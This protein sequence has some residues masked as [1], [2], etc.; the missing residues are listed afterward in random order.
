MAFEN[1][2]EMTEST[3]YQDI[4]NDLGVDTVD[5][6]QGV[7]TVNK[8]NSEMPKPA[9]STYKFRS[10]QSEQT[11]NE[12]QEK[13]QLDISVGVEHVLDDSETEDYVSTRE[14]YEKTLGVTEYDELRTKL[15]LKDDES[16]TD[17]YNRTHYVPEGFEMQAKL[18]LAEEKRKKL[19]AEVEAGNMSEEDFLYEAYGKD[20]LKE[21]GIDFSD[22]HYWYKKY[23]NKDYSDP[24]DNATYMLQLIDNARTLFEAETWYEV[25]QT[26]NIQELSQYVT[27]EVLPASTVAE[28]FPEMF[29]ELN[30][31]YESNEQIVK[32]YRGGMLQGFN[33]TI[34]ADGDGKIDYYYSTDGKL[35]NVNETG[36][37]ANTARA[38][39]ND[40]GS[41]NRIVMADTYLGEVSG[42]FLQGAGKLFTGVVDLFALA[43]GAIVD[44]FDGDGFG[45]TVAEVNASMQQ[46]WNG[47]PILGERDYV[48]DTGWKTSDGKTNWGNIGR[49][50][51][52]L[53]GYIVPA[54]VLAVCTGGGSLAKDAGQI[55][56]KEGAKATVKATAKAGAKAATKS[57]LSKAAS[58]T[59]KGVGTALKYTGK[60]AVALTKFNYGFGTGWTARI[61]SA[62]INAA[63]D[64]LQ[65]TATLQVNKERLGL[66]DGE[67]VGK[68]LML[69]GIDF[70]AGITLR[71]VGDETALKAMAKLNTSKVAQGSVDFL[72]KKTPNLWAKI[73]LNTYSTSWGRATV[74]GVNVAMDSAENI[75]TAVAQTSIMQNT[76]IGEA[77]KSVFNNPQFVMNL[78]YQGY[79]TVGDMYRVT[80]QK[81]AAAATD[82]LKM[83]TDFRAYVKKAITD[84]EA[85][86][87]IEGVK[88]LKNL[89]TEYDNLVLKYV[90]TD[91]DLKIKVKGEE[92]GVAKAFS[93]MA[94]EYN[95]R[96]E[97]AA[98]DSRKQTSLAHKSDVAKAEASVKYTKAE[99]ILLSLEE[100][101]TKLGFDDNHELFVKW[102]LDAN[103]AISAYQLAYNEAMFKQIHQDHLAYVKLSNSVFMGG[104]LGRFLYGKE[105][106]DVQAKL[107]TA[108]YSYYYNRKE[109]DHYDILGQYYEDLEDQSKLYNR[110]INKFESS[111]DDILK[112]LQTDTITGDIIQFL[113]KEGQPKVNA[114]G[115]PLYEVPEN[116]TKLSEEGKEVFK[117]WYNGL[118]NKQ[119]LVAEKALFVTIP[120]KGQQAEGTDTFKNAQDYMTI[121]GEIWT[122]VAGEYSPFVKLDDQHYLIKF[123]TIGKAFEDFSKTGMLVRALTN[124][125]LSASSND[126]ATAVAMRDLISIFAE[127]TKDA[128]TALEDNYNFIPGIINALKKGQAFNNKDLAYLVK[129]I[130]SYY[131]S[132]NKEHNTNIQL[133]KSMTEGDAYDTAQKLKEFM[134]DYSDLQDTLMA[135]DIRGE[136]SSEQNKAIVKFLNKYEPINA[137]GSK[138]FKDILA[139]AKAEGIFTDHQLSAMRQARNFIQGKTSTPLEN[140]KRSQ[141]SSTV[142]E[143]NKITHND[144]VEF[145]NTKFADDL[146]QIQRSAKGM[147]AQTVSLRDIGS[148]EDF[149]RY[150]SSR[151]GDINI[152]EL[153]DKD[154]LSYKDDYVVRTMKGIEDNFKLS[155]ADRTSIKNDLEHLFNKQTKN[156]DNDYRNRQEH[157]QNTLKRLEYN[158]TDSMAKEVDIVRE[159]DSITEDLNNSTDM[160]IINLN[161]LTGAEG[162]KVAKAIET[163]TA[164]SAALSKAS[165]VDDIQKILFADNE[166]LTNF[167]KEL[168]TVRRL[169]DIYGSNYIRLSI[170]SQTL[171]DILTDLGYNVNEKLKY[172]NGEVLIPGVYFNNDTKGIK[173]TTNAEEAAAVRSHLQHRQNNIEAERL[174]ASTKFR[175]PMESITNASGSIVLLD[176][177]EKLQP[178]DIIFNTLN[179]V[180]EFN[181]IVA[182]VLKHNIIEVKRGKNAGALFKHLLTSTQGIAAKGS[183]DVEMEKALGVYKIVN[184]FSKLYD[185]KEKKDIQGMAISL[186][187][188][189]ALEKTFKSSKVKPFIFTQNDSD[190]LTTIVTLNPE[191]TPKDF[192][193]LVFKKLTAKNSKITSLAQVLPIYGNNEQVSMTDILHNNITQGERTSIASGY[194][195]LTWLEESESLSLDVYDF[196]KKHG[197]SLDF[198][199]KKISNKDYE[200]ALKYLEGKS[201]NDVIND[202]SL[203]DNMFVKMQRNAY[204]ANQEI[205]ESFINSLRSQLPEDVDLDGVLRILGDSNARRSIGVAIRKALIDNKDNLKLDNGFV[206]VDDTLVSAIRENFK[207]SVLPGR[208]EQAQGYTTETDQVTGIQFGSINKQYEDIEVTDK[209]IQDLL[210]VVPLEYTSIVDDSLSVTFE[211]KLMS[212]LESSSYGTDGLNISTKDLYQL[213]PEE[214]DDLQLMFSGNSALASA[215]KTLKKSKLYIGLHEKRDP[216]RTKEFKGKKT[217]TVQ[218]IRGDIATTSEIAK[219]KFEPALEDE[220]N[221]LIKN[222]KH[223]IA[224]E[225]FIKISNIDDPKFRVNSMMRILAEKLNCSVT[226]YMDNPASL[227]I[228]NLTLGE[229]L[230]YMFKNLQS[231]AG[232]LQEAYGI[233]N[234]DTAI[235]IAVNYMLYSTG[236]QQQGAHPEF[237]IIDKKTGNVVDIAMSGS[238][239][240][241]DDGLITRLYKDYFEVNNGELHFKKS[242]KHRISSGEDIEVTPDN[243]CAL[244]LQRNA[245]TTSFK[246]A[247]Y[248]IEIYD[249]QGHEQ[250]FKNMIMDKI[251]I[252]AQANGFDTSSVDD[253]PRIAKAFMEFVNSR[254]NQATSGFNRRI[255]N[256]GANL[257][258]G[259]DKALLG[260]LEGMSVSNDRL[261]DR[262]LALKYHSDA[263]LEGVNIRERDINDIIN[264]GTTNEELL[265]TQGAQAFIA[266]QNRA[267]S[268]VDDLDAEVTDLFKL[269]EEQERDAKFNTSLKHLAKKYKDNKT[270]AAVAKLEA[271]IK[272]LRDTIR[273]AQEDI[274][275]TKAVKKFMLSSHEKLADLIKENK[276]FEQDGKTLTPL[277]TVLTDTIKA[278]KNVSDEE[279]AINVIKQMVRSS[280]TAEANAFKVLDCNISTIL[281]RPKFESSV[282]INSTPVALSE[283][284]NRPMLVFDTEVF[285][286]GTKQHVYEVSATY[287]VPGKQPITQTRYIKD[288]MVTSIQTLEATYPDFYKEYYKANKGTRVS[289]DNYLKSNYTNQAFDD[290]LKI[291]NADD[292]VL[293]GFNSRN[294][295]IPQLESNGVLTQD[296]YPKLFANQLDLFDIVK[297]LP[298][299]ENINLHGGMAT[300]RHIYDQLNINN[301]LDVSNAHFSEADTAM[302]KQVL[303]QIIASQVTDFKSDLLSDMSSIYKSITGNDIDYA[304]LQ[305]ALDASTLKYQDVKQRY[306]KDL[307]NLQAHL[308][309]VLS[310]KNHFTNM[311]KVIQVANERDINRKVNAQIKNLNKQLAVGI[312]PRY[313]DFATNYASPKTKQLLLDVIAYKLRGITDTNDAKATVDEVKKTMNDIGKLLTDTTSENDI[314]DSLNIN[315]YS[316]VYKLGID[317]DDFKAWQEENSAY[318]HERLNK[319]FHLSYGD[320]LAM[321]TDRTHVKNAVAY[322]TKLLSDYVDGFGFLPDQMKTLIKNEL[323]NYYDFTG[324]YKD[325]SDQVYLDCFSNLDNDIM[326]YLLTDPLLNHSFEQLYRLAQT[327]SDKPITL[328]GGGSEYL[329]NDTVYMTLDNYCKL[330]GIEEVENIPDPVNEYIP[331][332]RHPL[333]KFDSIHFFKIKL[334]DDNQNIDVAINMDTMLS[335]LNGDFD[336]DHITM[337]R[338]SEALSTFAE[339]INTKSGKNTSYDILDNIVES[340]LKGNVKRSLDPDSV[341]KSKDLF[342]VNTDKTIRDHIIK[343]LDQLNKGSTDVELYNKLKTNFINKFKSTYPEDILDKVYIYEANDVSDMLYNNQVIYYSDLLSLNDYQPNTLAKRAYTIAQMSKYKVLSFTDTQSGMFQKGFLNEDYTQYGDVDLVDNMIRLSNSTRY[344]ID[345]VDDISSV[346]PADIKNDSRF[347]TILSLDTTNSNKL[348]LILKI[349]QMESVGNS[350]YKTTVLDATKALKEST[351]NDPFVKAFNRFTSDNTGDAFF[352]TIDQI[353]SIKKKIRGNSFTTSKDKDFINTL[354][355]LAPKFDETIEDS[356]YNPGK[357]MNVIYDL[358]EISKNPEDTVTFVGW[359]KDGGANGYRAV[360]PANTDV[361][362]NQVLSRVRKYKKLGIMSPA[363]VKLLGIKYN[364]NCQYRYVDTQNGIVTY[365]E[366]FNVDT[367]KTV[368][369]GNQASKATPTASIKDLS[370]IKD[371][372][373]QDLIKNNNVSLI[374]NFQDT[375]NPKKSSSEFKVFS[376]SSNY[377]MYK[378]DGTVTDTIDDARYIIAKERRNLLELPQSWNRDLK[379]TKFEELAYGNNMLGTG[380]IGLTYGIFVDPESNQLIIDNTK[381]NHVKEQINS[382]RNYDRFSVDATQLY[383]HL[384]IAAIVNNLSPEELGD[385]TKQQFYID[386]I[387]GDTQE[388]IKSHINK[389]YPLKGNSAKLLDLNLYNRIYGMQQAIVDENNIRLTSGS[390]SGIDKE[391]IF[392]SAN[393]ELHGNIKDMYN[394][395]SG[396]NMSTL[397][398]INYL[399]EGN[400][401]VT[402]TVARKAEQYGFLT[403]KQIPESDVD[404]YRT[405]SNT[406]SKLTQ[407]FQKPIEYKYSDKK[408]FNPD[409]DGDYDSYYTKF[410]FSHGDKLVDIN[411]QRL[412][413]I[414]GNNQFRDIREQ[415]R[416]EWYTRGQRVANLANSLLNIKGTYKDKDQILQALNPNTKALVSMSLPM[417]EIQSNGKIRYNQRRISLG[418]DGYKEVPISEVRQ[419]L[420][421]QRRSPYY[422][423]TLNKLEEQTKA[424]SDYFLTKHSD[425]RK[426]LNP[427]E[428]MLDRETVGTMKQSFSL[429]INQKYKEQIDKYASKLRSADPTYSAAE[430]LQPTLYSGEIVQGHNVGRNLF[431]E[432]PIGLQQGLAHQNPESLKQDRN[433]RQVAVDEQYIKQNYLSKL[434]IIHDIASR[435][436]CGDTLHLFGYVVG[437]QSKLDTLTSK[438][439]LSELDIKAR[440]EDIGITD[441]KKFI[442]DFE[443][444]HYGLATKFYDLIQDLG[445]RSN[446]I[447][448]ASNEPGQNIFFMLLP[449]EYKAR[450]DKKKYVV[451]MLS[452]TTTTDMTSIPAYEAYDVFGALNNTIT[453]VSKRAAIYQN[454][455]RLKQDG[456][457]DSL[458]IQTILADSFKDPALIDKV[459]NT[460]AYDPGQFDLI[461]NRLLD[462]FNNT[463]LSAKIEEARDLIFNKT[464]KDSKTYKIGEAYLKVFEGISELTSNFRTS[465]DETLELANQYNSDQLDSMIYAYR[466]LQDIYAQVCSFNPEI[467]KTLF[468]KINNYAEQNNLAL[469]DKFGRKYDPNMDYK[470]SNTSLEYLP[471]AL[472][473]NLTQYDN[474]IMSETLVGNVFFM[475]KSLANVFADQVFVKVPPNTIQKALQKSSGWCVKM[476]MSSPFKLLDRFFKFTLFDAATLNT[477]NARTMFEQSK[478]YKDLRGYFSSKGGYASPEL[479]E[480]LR[481]QGISFDGTNF[482]GLISGDINAQTPTLFKTYTDKV[483]NAFTFQ[484]LSQRYA[485]WLATKKAIENEDY[486]TLGSAYYLRDKM[487][488]SG[489]TSGEQAA[490]AMGQN[491][492]SMNDFPSLSKKFNKNGFVFTTFPLA[493]VRWGV[494]E[495]RSA[496]SAIHSLFTEGL[497]GSGAKWL[498]RNSVGIIG[499]ILLEQ[500]LIALIADMY[501]VDE[502]DEDRKEWEKVGALPNVTQTLIQGQ[503]IMDSFSSMSVP[504][505]VIN[506][507]IDTSKQDEEGNK[508]GMDGLT[509]FIMSNVVSHV[510]PIV[511]GVG[512]VI[513]KKDVIGD[514][515]IDTSNQYNAFENVFRKTSAYF[516][517]SAGANAAT[518][519]LFKN[520]STESGLEK[521]KNAAIK[522]VNAELGNTKAQKEN[523]KNYYKAMG[524]IN[525]Y[526]YSGETDNVYSNS[527]NFNYSNYSVVKSKIYS[528]MNSE[529]SASEVYSA[530]NDFLASGYTLSEVRSALRNCSISGKLSKINKYEDFIASLTGSELQNLKTALAYEQYMFPW[531]EDNISSISSQIQKNNRRYDYNFDS[532]YRTNYFYDYYEPTNYTIPT[533]SYNYSKNYKDSFDTYKSLQDQLAYNQRQAEY[534]RNQKQW[535]DK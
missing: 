398:L 290:L 456:V 349:K 176:A 434:Q 217:S 219:G 23:K 443:K 174:K 372:T 134:T 526:L 390:G 233:G 401:L 357:E 187:N 374:S 248:D 329:K 213:S 387:S 333:D 299:T 162:N 415:D 514:Q 287:Y 264:L 277:A 495:L 136:I 48:A 313:I 458:K 137:N 243:L 512:E 334:I 85:R 45:S 503:P 499:T 212:M 81:V 527:E 487:I 202:S 272:D 475:D 61:S 47:I 485:Y 2:S 292:A 528:L 242:F 121:A 105:A 369:E 342:K 115:T 464:S 484:T 366:S 4:N 416:D 439:T 135:T 195:T 66:S 74:A 350:T 156:Q 53:I 427:D 533:S 531:L 379:D 426:L 453:A 72:T 303:D 273:S 177:D 291:A 444:Q 91:N 179:N 51:A 124:L 258:K 317:K 241:Q 461:C 409:V 423:D 389:G 354:K 198:A 412:S 256:S 100:M 288:D 175:D 39:Y 235:N 388:F 214:L 267:L 146:K 278:I 58:A 1:D 509:R 358:E 163:Q 250:Q 265:S 200:D 167:K 407:I 223:S 283:L 130:D 525:N 508:T 359:D 319:L 478:A 285:Y 152:E 293:L 395:H 106:R 281:N 400:A 344:L 312:N 490:F 411:G 442:S 13:A 515:I 332:I 239:S 529:A 46:F 435:E 523:R 282:M 228:S 229:N 104:A 289:F 168:R 367:A 86:Q 491:L 226:P 129:D 133:P 142:S 314:I 430:E 63:K 340:V 460:T 141:T 206:D 92:V 414:Y 524:I 64:I 305:G 52:N 513:T 493:A 140:L 386:K 7:A 44:I 30:K 224:T 419:E 221:R 393:S 67:I 209:L 157:L 364:K 298:S 181:A 89:L 65:T 320:T 94:E 345:S 462:K 373:L 352:K 38:V 535:E 17:Y 274:V 279:L 193:D 116:F 32:Y 119:K 21:Q 432:Q 280:N 182:E 183:T 261:K 29:E 436:G 496:T 304:K 391:K 394:M 402:D 381:Y 262:E 330:K 522:A 166:S 55:A 421:N 489:M 268:I 73:A 322:S 71:S 240:D 43:G 54:V 9:A 125:K 353:V 123:E 26:K 158:V 147:E 269:I 275:K 301:K 405:F 216:I 454:A 417:A 78:A 295:D 510:N 259:S 101:A 339:T 93:D 276:Y 497:S 218:S 201:I 90:D 188:A 230:Y 474:Y 413:Q 97:G 154:Y 227:M 111:G 365:I 37:G 49:Q 470:L 205:K 35:Y 335:K 446:K 306:S 145:F 343:D 406:N 244:R 511:K 266:D 534:K 428:V 375:F 360:K 420:Y 325:L 362:S 245:L 488:N 263:D 28:L 237:I 8:V 361:Q 99:A 472:Q 316:L 20:L 252:V 249:F 498:G 377:T 186:A 520:D 300:L 286:N 341:T 397:E 309:K 95:T 207:Y 12:A 336:G 160:V 516:I 418:P 492:G 502:D 191:I 449:S 110:L 131:A 328:R 382:L 102:G 385:R 363:D 62:A 468:S 457:I 31:Y 403:N 222:S 76:S 77:F 473:R 14:L 59:A 530:I 173:L 231:F 36:K 445:D 480:F 331:V 60:A 408:V 506:L 438:D 257:Y 482:D 476:L 192:S 151:Y 324:E 18:L 234:K 327:V 150:L 471:K 96:A 149:N 311:A 441:A 69:G 378:V 68:S 321:D 246:D 184:A 19:Y 75:I 236:M 404:P 494:G 477:A 308:T 450:G 465:L 196:V 112:S 6:V 204:R 25:S 440:L 368:T 15:H 501:G 260:S 103:K 507:F 294:F 70:V 87:D 159:L 483:G 466:Q 251:R 356:I 451:N 132:Y 203:D 302:T 323:V 165:T 370:K 254:E 425:N 144:I 128:D 452:N 315:K 532:Y 117:A 3:N 467:S 376:D 504:R 271:E 253:R 164:K 247:D 171:K 11:E 517:G 56:V 27:G 215:I 98:A 431:K 459:R 88:N 392:T 383:E 148:E 318:T 143:E 155:D 469:V 346:I 355:F 113:T 50:G 138:H 5:K 326:D 40:D 16:F 107:A 371:K 83:D 210:Y 80:P 24:R 437:L 518:K 284:A 126:A 139:V 337:L 351:S 455:Q 429:D 197:H 153:S 270:P 84:C 161:N 220:I 307:D 180:D 463:T 384:A 172:V 109:L 447:S 380:G 194:T 479:D 410:D 170:H 33:P 348:E 82:A 178:T 505:E 519:H 114:N 255:L 22:Y 500:A 122:E 34:D 521:V 232:S 118:D 424:S 297:E 296:L 42:S 10:K 396:P 338:P 310:D 448:Q 79:N 211:T 481:T 199:G 169:K 399:N 57:L 108:I 190:P 225:Q 185:Q 120:G 208:K 486:S 433:I 238:A 189:K 127:N 41:L 347:K 422:W